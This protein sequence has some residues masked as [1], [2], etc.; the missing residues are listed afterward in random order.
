M[1]VTHFAIVI[2]IAK[3]DQLLA[4][5]NVSG[6]HIFHESAINLILFKIYAIYSTVT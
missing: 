5:E 4:K 1:A 2:I 6:Q 3:S